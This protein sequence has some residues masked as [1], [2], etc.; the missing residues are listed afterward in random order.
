MRGFTLL[1]LLLTMAIVVILMGLSY[2]IYTGFEA[3]ANRQHAA[4][5]LFQLAA[6]LENYYLL[7]NSY[8]GANDMDMHIPSLNQDL[9]YQLHVNS[10]SDSGYLIEADPVGA[11]ASR[12]TQCGTLFLDENNVKSISG[13][14]NP[15]I[16]WH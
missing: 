15:Q 7:N 9:T 16:C 4:T 13:S 2:P 3:R 14:G 5:A 6:N 8:E 11:Q 1:E 10:V 12:D